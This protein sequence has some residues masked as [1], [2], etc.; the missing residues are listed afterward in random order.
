M[1]GDRRWTGVPPDRSRSGRAA[2][3]CGW[4]SSVRNAA[5][6]LATPHWSPRFKDASD[7]P[8]MCT[9][10]ACWPFRVPTWRSFRGPAPSADDACRRSCGADKRV[11]RRGFDT[12]IRTRPQILL[13]GSHGNRCERIL[14]SARSRRLSACPCGRS[15]SSPFGPGVRA[16]P[17]R[18]DPSRPAWS[19]R[20]RIRP[21]PLAGL[22]RPGGPPRVRSFSPLRLAR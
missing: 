1:K 22:L 16:I 7:G 18:R 5:C 14:F 17:A 19:G 11:G 2:D 9:A 20:V 3:A 8:R 15:A 12:V 6:W 13:T 4:Q 10:G 21:E